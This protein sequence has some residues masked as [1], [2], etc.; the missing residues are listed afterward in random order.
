MT[1]RVYM[2]VTEAMHFFCLNQEQKKN[3]I[4]YAFLHSNDYLHLNNLYI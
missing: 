3:H 1:E 2:V 4:G